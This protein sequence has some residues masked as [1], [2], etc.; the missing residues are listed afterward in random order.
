MAEQTCRVHAGTDPDDGRHDVGQLR[1]G[2]D[3]LDWPARGV[4]VGVAPGADFRPPGAQLR[5]GRHCSIVWVVQ[6]L[7]KS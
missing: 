7:Q 5:V 2:R 1:P 3:V 4:G 6:G